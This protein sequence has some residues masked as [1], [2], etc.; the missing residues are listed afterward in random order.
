LNQKYRGKFSYL[1]QKSNF[2]A[3]VILSKLIEGF[4][5]FRD[6]A[7]YFGKKIAFYKRA[8]ILIGDLYSAFQG[9]GW[10]NLKNLDRL[11]VFADYKLPQILREYGIL[12]YNKDLSEKIDKKNPILAGSPEEV[13]I[14][15]NTVWAGE[16]IRRALKERKINLLSIEIDWILWEKSHQKRLKFRPHHLTKTIFY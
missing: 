9:T 13:E 16:M 14:R 11:T 6:E 5:S 12:V 7:R 10:G 3:S 15:A 1:I 8:Q 2:D 4:S